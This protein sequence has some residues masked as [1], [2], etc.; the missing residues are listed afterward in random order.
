[1]QD[2][3]EK[4]LADIR[5]LK[6]KREKEKEGEGECPSIA[7]RGIKNEIAQLKQ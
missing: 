6:E 3:L 7:K 5:K 4:L 1:M 2:F